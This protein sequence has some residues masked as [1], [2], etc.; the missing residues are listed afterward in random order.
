MAAK[1]AKKDAHGTQVGAGNK[2]ISKIQHSGFQKCD[3]KKCIMRVHV[4]PPFLP[5]Y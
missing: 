3:L 1:M 5:Y 4:S 2:K